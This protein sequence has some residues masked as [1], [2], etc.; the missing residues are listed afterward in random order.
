M[1]LRFGILSLLLLAA[2][3]AL[4]QKT[5]HWR[6]LDVAARLDPAGRLHVNETQ[7]M[8]FHGDWNGGERSFTV[9]FGQSLSLSGITRIDPSGA[10]YPL[11]QGDLSGVDQWS[12]ADSS[13]VRWRSRL[14][15]DPP[16]DNQEIVYRLDYTVDRILKPIGER[17][18]LNHDFAFSNREGVIEKFTLKLG[19][20]GWSAEEP[21]PEQF[22]ETNLAPGS[23]YVVRR[24]LRYLGE[25]R[26]A[27]VV[28]GVR[29]EIGYAVAAAFALAVFLVLF[30]FFRDESRTGRFAPLLPIDRINEQW[31]QD[32]VFTFSPEFVGAAW[33][34][35]TSAAEVAA[36]L[37]RMTAEA[38]LS[39]R[40]EK[41]GLFRPDEL[42]LTLLVDRES[43]E[44]YEGALIRSLFVAG[45]ETS[46][47]LIREHYKSTGFDPVSKIRDPLRRTTARIGRARGVSKNTLRWSWKPI[48]LLVLAG[49]VCLVLSGFQGEYNIL[50]AALGPSF[51]IVAMV[52]GII[53][54]TFYRRKV[55]NLIVTSLG[56]VIPIL[57][58]TAGVLAFLILGPAAL[59]LAFL[60]LIG[61]SL[62]GIAVIGLILFLATGGDVGD[63]LE[64]R[65]KLAAAREYFKHQLRSR[66]PKLQDAWFPYLLAFGLGPHIDGWFRSFGGAS[67]AATSR[68]SSGSSSS[69]SSSSGWSGGGGAFG[70]AGAT[71]SWA[72][73]A[74]S[75]AAGVSAP[76]SSGGGGGGGG[77]GSSGG[78][79]GGGW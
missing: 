34:D 15:S 50:F 51:L 6:R 28:F 25:G 78:G 27:G 32:N 29:R 3:P 63:R 75:M 70:G 52:F 73:A 36:I 47:K 58:I 14:P 48:V 12:W 16:F 5:L 46:T 8:V 68:F 17:Y 66:D 72:L 38:K 7:A 45:N 54:T 13:T 53:G 55:T 40:V 23:G 19:L 59:P 33:D 20:S 44:G 24:E 56:F 79:G 77:G 76:S 74:G 57:L 65:R 31:L 1:R 67:R 43:L 41:G 21:L 69:G 37:A 10:E 4:G 30:F 60:L 11:Q 22:E 26:P 64:M 39:S 35:R 71:A 18:L 9:P 62:C 2:L 61:L 49:I 42:H